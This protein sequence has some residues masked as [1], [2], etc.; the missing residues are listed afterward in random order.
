MTGTQAEE[1]PLQRVLTRYY[2][3]GIPEL[4]SCKI[5]GTGT[6]TVEGQEIDYSFT[7]VIELQK[8]F[9]WE[10]ESY[11]LRYLECYDGDFGHQR[12]GDGNLQTFEGRDGA[13]FR[14][15]LMME[16][17]A[18]VIPLTEPGVKIE[19]VNPNMIEAVFGTGD[20]V[21]LHFDP[22]TYNPSKVR[23]KRFNAG[24]RKEMMMRIE[25]SDWMRAAKIVMPVTW[26]AAWEDTQ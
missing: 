22:E 6:T 15:R 8:R 20:T 11:D 13:S 1:N 10:F 3:D 9:R 7:E 21:W 26:R 19:V 2:P 5:A 12:I 18:F 14:M 16:S 25:L 4:E 17:A 24:A 23:A